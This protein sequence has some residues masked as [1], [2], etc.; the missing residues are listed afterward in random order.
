MKEYTRIISFLYKNKIYNYYLDNKNKKFFTTSDID[1]NEK[2]IT[3]EEYIKLL[4]L[5][6]KKYSLKNIE[7]NDY[8]KEIINE[9]E[10]NNYQKSRKKRMIPKVIVSGVLMVLTPLV[11]YGALSN[12]KSSVEFN[13]V[14]EKNLK[15]VKNQS[16]DYNVTSET[17]IFN[18]TA[19]N[20]IVK[21]TPE[22]E[23]ETTKE[24]TETELENNSELETEKEQYS[25]SQNDQLLN[26]TALKKYFLSD[27]I[28]KKIEVDTYIDNRDLSQRLS[29][30]DMDYLDMALNTKK[31]T[32]DDFITVINNNK[33]IP[34]KFKSLVIDYVTQVYKKYPNIELRP[35]YKNL[36]NLEVEECDE[37]KMLETTLSADSVGCYVKKDDKIYVLEDKKYDK[38]TWDYQV[39]FHELSHCLRDVEYKDKDGNLIDVQF[40]GINYYDVPNSE[41]IN[42][43]FAVSL[44]DYEEKDIAYQFQSNAHKLMIESMDNYNLSDYV[45]HSM[46][47]YISKLDEYNQDD[48]YAVKI[49]ALMAAQFEDYHDEDFKA[50]QSEYYPIYDYISKMY[51]RKNINSNM[52]YDEARSVMDGMLDKL[53]FDVPEEYEIDKNHFYDYLNDYCNSIGIQQN[54]IKK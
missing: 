34:K 1:G 36:K 7:K 24:S 44:F 23:K 29:I 53:L 47:Y 45:M 21:T 10:L 9:I 42:S 27:Y 54:N 25:N 14:L 41:A 17:K 15:E 28:D 18:N 51:L 38:G 43:L 2:Y 48:N 50:P 22:K 40:D 26:S 11:V 6:K 20:K 32:L 52:S 3:I 8:K 30:Y 39:I 12:Y 4:S 33:K 19:E 46:T 5:F 35:F 49:M 16:N 37:I 13:K 31:P